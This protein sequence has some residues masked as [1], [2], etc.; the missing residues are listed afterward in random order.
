MPKVTVNGIRMNYEEAGAGEA[1]ILIHGLGFTRR[2]WTLQ[3]PVF[4]K[5]YRTITPDCR[6]HGD[7]DKPRKQHSVLDLSEDIHELMNSLCIGRAHVL[8]I[9]M[10]GMVAQLFAAD[11]PQRV[12]KLVLC[13]TRSR[14]NPTFANRLLHQIETLDPAARA[15]MVLRD[16]VT[17]QIPEDIIRINQEDLER[18]TTDAYVRDL[19]AVM[20]FD[21][22]DRLKEIR[23]P[24]LIVVGDHDRLMGE[25]KFLNSL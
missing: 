3:M 14:P 15:K 18:N 13:D 1:L 7:S 21:A 2:H 6:G 8:G 16:E 4:S 10:G 5:Y 20:D 24:T 19:K 12:N 9:S 25:C 11:H 22:A 23:A 17:Y